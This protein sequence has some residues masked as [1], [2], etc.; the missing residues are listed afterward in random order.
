MHSLL[1]IVVSLLFLLVV[2]PLKAF[3][4]SPVIINEVLVH[5]S[6]GGKE[7]VEFYVTDSTDIKSYWLDDDADF[8]SDSGGS[9]KKSLETVLLG[10]DNQ[11]YFIEF[12]GSMF[13][14]TEDMVV[15]YNK[16][17]VIVDQIKYNDGPGYDVTFGRTPDGTGGLYILGNPTRGSPNSGPRPTVTP[18]PEPTAKPTKAP[19]A[20]KEPE[21]QPTARTATRA[22]A[23][24][25]VSSPTPARA[26]TPKVSSTSAKQASQGAFPTAILGAQTT[27]GPTRIPLPS[28]PVKVQGASNTPA[29]FTILGAGFIIACAVI[30]FIKKLRS[31]K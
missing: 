4:A 15:L 24:P 17:G 16:D 20:T 9:A 30:V 21:A 12:S 7:W 23:T 5:P 11:H 13:N 28:I 1:I 3:A 19:T 22:T 26:T 2:F 6:A 18:T 14:N 10:N 27:A 25:K 29:L 31:A 8:A